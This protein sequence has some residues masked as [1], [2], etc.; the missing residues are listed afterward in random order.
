MI[1][2]VSID[3]MQEHITRET[4]KQHY[5]Q[6][7]STSIHLHTLEHILNVLDEAVQNYSKDRVINKSQQ[8]IQIKHDLISDEIDNYLKEKTFG[9]L[10]IVFS[11]IY[12]KMSQ[13]EIKEIYHSLSSGVN[14]RS[15][16]SAVNSIAQKRFQVFI[17]YYHKSFNRAFEYLEKNLLDDMSTR[18]IQIIEQKAKELLPSSHVA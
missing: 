16:S 5:F 3:V 17:A 12:L 14:S 6:T 9:F 15:P 11:L 1:P 8:F 2:P 4:M 13:D 7:I 18:N 10:H